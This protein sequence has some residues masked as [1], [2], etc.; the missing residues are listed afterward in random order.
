[1]EQKLSE[2][3]S[4]KHNDLTN[5]F[6]SQLS[7]TAKLNKIKLNNFF[8]ETGAQ[9][10]FFNVHPESS[11]KSQREHSNGYPWPMGNFFMKEEGDVNHVSEG[12]M[13]FSGT[14]MRFGS[15]W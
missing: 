12:R 10:R 5:S 3:I 14:F 11:T 8:Y 4:S 9:R 13:G 6:S 15:L 1:M 7:F 2:N